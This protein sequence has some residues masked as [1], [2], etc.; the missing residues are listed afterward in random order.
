MRVLF[1][2][3]LACSLPS[4][5]RP[6]PPFIPSTF[7]YLLSLPFPY[8]SLHLVTIPSESSFEVLAPRSDRMLLIYSQSISFHLTFL[9]HDFFG[10][11]I[12]LLHSHI[13]YR[14]LKRTPSFTLHSVLLIC[15]FHASCIS[16]SLYKRNSWTS[17]S[18][19]TNALYPFTCHF[20]PLHMLF[21]TLPTLL[22]ALLFISSPT[23]PTY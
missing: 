7:L 21:F 22:L 9:L 23:A 4:S 3:H 18:T 8:L 16:V 11:V 17:S 1:R 19:V 20:H 2:L 10:I 14:T 5:H 6:T 13:A 12:S 15:I